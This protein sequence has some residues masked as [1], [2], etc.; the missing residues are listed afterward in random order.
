MTDVPLY[1]GGGGGGP[2]YTT[3]HD[4]PDSQPQFLRALSNYS[5]RVGHTVTFTCQAKNVKGY[6]VGR[7]ILEIFYFK[8]YL[9][10]I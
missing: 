7:L 1:A 3:F 10:I 8:R 2:T 9:S 4:I 6:K 5:V